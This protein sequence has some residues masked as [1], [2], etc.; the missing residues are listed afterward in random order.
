MLLDYCRDLAD[1]K[2]Q[3]SII[4]KSARRFLE[5]E[6]DSISSFTEKSKLIGLRLREY[7]IAGWI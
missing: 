2:F 5:S 3:E 6:Q 4:P 7:Y 1:E